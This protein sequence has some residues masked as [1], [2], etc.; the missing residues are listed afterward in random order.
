[1]VTVV[2]CRLPRGADDSFQ[3]EPGRRRSIPASADHGGGAYDLR[4]VPGAD[5]LAPPDAWISHEVP[6]LRWGLRPLHGFGMDSV[7]A[8]ST[9]MAS[10]L[11]APRLHPRF[12]KRYNLLDPLGP[13]ECGHRAQGVARDRVR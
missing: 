1:M 12:H 3:T 13:T 7:G 9:I 10:S 2:L 4:T 6:H 8:I 11:T 5:R